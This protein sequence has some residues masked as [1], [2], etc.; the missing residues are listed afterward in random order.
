MDEPTVLYSREL[1]GGGVVLIEALPTPDGPHRARLCVER[2]SDVR[3]RSGHAPPVVAEAEA[4]SRAQVFQQLY[5][6]ASDNVALA[7]AL[8]QRLGPPDT[9]RTPPTA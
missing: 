1:P 4:E 8:I 9:G 6:L 5:G 3:R 7:R 2:R